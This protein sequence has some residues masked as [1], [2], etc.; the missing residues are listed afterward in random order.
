MLYDLLIFCMLYDL[1]RFCMLYDLLKLCM[2]YGLLRFCMLT[3]L[4]TTTFLMVILYIK[5]FYY[6]KY[7]DATVDNPLLVHV[8]PV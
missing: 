6:Y 3:I 2:L 1:L 5:M 7:R 4:N 8:E